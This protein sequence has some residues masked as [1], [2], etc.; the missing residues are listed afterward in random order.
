MKKEDFSG[1]K[2][3]YCQA[4]PP[5]D[6]VPSMEKWCDDNCFPKNPAHINCPATHCNCTKIPLHYPKSNFKN[7]SIYENVL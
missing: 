3:K 2:S 5:W 7:G 6:Q 1:Y 4:V